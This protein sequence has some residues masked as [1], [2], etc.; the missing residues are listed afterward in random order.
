MTPLKSG[1]FIVGG[2]AGIALGGDLVVDSASNI[3]EYFGLSQTFIGLTIVALG[4]SLPELVTSMVAA[5]RG[6]NDLAVGNVVGSNIFNILLILGI[7]SVI[8][9]IHLEITAIYDTVILI[10]ASVIVYAAALS[11]RKIERKEGFL[12]LVVYTVFFVY[13]LIR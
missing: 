12:F 5:G 7:S 10:A 8:T 3:A 6:E 4:T 1:L 9:P 13:I 11:K 2:L